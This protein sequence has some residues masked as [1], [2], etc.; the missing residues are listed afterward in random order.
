[1]PCRH[2]ETFVNALKICAHP[3]EVKKEIQVFEWTHNKFTINELQEIAQLEV[4]NEWEKY[5]HEPFNQL[6]I[7]VQV[8]EKGSKVKKKR[9]PSIGE[10]VK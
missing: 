8:I 6:T 1:M 7:P 9:I 10:I 4:I 3:I 2:A 5:N